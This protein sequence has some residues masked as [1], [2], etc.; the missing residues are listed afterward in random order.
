MINR[1]KAN[2]ELGYRCGLLP[3]VGSSIKL[4]IESL[5]LLR[6]L[7]EESVGT[8][9]AARLVE[10]MGQDLTLDSTAGS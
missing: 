8:L 5:D 7:L 3:K 1:K 2:R 4:N 9:L 6:F 10:G